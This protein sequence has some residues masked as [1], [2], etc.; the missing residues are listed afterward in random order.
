MAI[1]YVNSNNAAA[2]VA[3]T[4]YSIG[5]MVMC[6]PAQSSANRASRIYECTTGGTSHATTEPTWNTTLDGTTSDNDVVWTTRMPTSWDYA[7][8]SIFYFLSYNGAYIADGDIIKIH[9]THNEVVPTTYYFERFPCFGISG[10]PLIIVCVD[11]DNGDAVSTGAVVTY[12]KT[13][14][15]YFH[16][17]FVSIGVSWVYACT[18]TGY[19]NAFGWY[20][21][22]PGLTTLKLTGSGKYIGD[23]AA[24]NVY[25]SVFWTD[26]NIEFSNADNTF[27][28]V[29]LFHWESGTLIAS[30]GV[31]KLLDTSYGPR[32]SII[33]FSNIDLTALGAN[34]LVK[35][36]ESLPNGIIE[37]TRCKF[38]TNLSGLL[39]TSFGSGGYKGTIKFHQC[40]FAG[41]TWK[42][43]E[44]S[45]EGQVESDNTIYR[46]GGATD[47]I[48]PISWK[49]ASSTMVSEP[50]IP[51]KTPTINLWNDTV[52]EITLTIH[53]IIDSVTNLQDD[54]VWL[55]VDYPADTTS[56]LGA[57]KTTRVMYVGMADLPVS[58]E[59]WVEEMG[60]PNLFKLEATFT[61]GQAGPIS[62][63]VC[64]GKPSTT[65]Y[66]CPKAVI[67]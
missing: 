38:P 16:G 37:F 19:S 23:Y 57:L 26:G 60:N 53:G 43:Y 45:A 41:K 42:F 59:D 18:I 21:H 24:G 1:Y 34:T 67:S 46:T 50:T 31:T 6:A 10:L 47:G 11:K 64:V 12:Q 3:G 7:H 22:G 28:K 36:Y 15:L 5:D 27:K 9:K 25:A 52:S 66:V 29:G 49:M 48:T 61:P 51:L 33:K 4:A 62:V 8:G 65:I 54:E 63:R 32:D 14:D 40:S 55:E 35:P 30:N 20:L 17:S 58:T 13:N 39:S 44:I 56:G 2:W